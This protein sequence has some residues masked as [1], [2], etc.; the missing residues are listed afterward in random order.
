MLLKFHK[1][2]ANR[3]YVSRVTIDEVCNKRE[4]HRTKKVIEYSHV[5]TAIKRMS[6][7]DPNLGPDEVNLEDR[8]EFEKRLVSHLE[9]NDVTIVDYPS[10][11]HGDVIKYAS[12]G[13]RPFKNKDTGYKDYLIW[14]NIKELL[15]KDHASELYL[16]TRD[17]DFHS[18]KT[19]HGDLVEDLKASEIDAT[20]VRVLN[21]I[22]D[23]NLKFLIPTFE[24]K[25][26]ETLVTEE[27]IK[28][29]K[30]AISE[31]LQQYVVG[32]CL[33]ESNIKTS[34]Q[35]EDVHIVDIESIDSINLGDARLVEDTK[36]QITASSV[37]T[38]LL[39]YAIESAFIDSLS[40]NAE[41]GDI[42]H[43]VAAVSEVRQICAE[44]A[45]I[46]DLARVKIERLWTYE[47]SD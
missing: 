43:S 26:V 14:T 39:S 6:F 28:F 29:L 33:S 13:R 34:H 47:L 19:L 30:E 25:P 24:S 32:N 42:E 23:F 31:D 16:L 22:K 18:D 12:T 9:E 27:R 7:L 11:G 45:V 2:V 46:F 17:G 40:P 35:Y 5:R 15:I 10:I 41:V 21:S 8:D 4:E 1:R 3:I 38:V 44:T 37:L 20:R 36:I